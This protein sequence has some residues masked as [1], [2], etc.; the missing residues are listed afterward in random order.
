MMAS[1]NPCAGEERERGAAGI[2]QFVTIK[3]L[4]IGSVRS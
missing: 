1:I 3:T 2:R 4:W